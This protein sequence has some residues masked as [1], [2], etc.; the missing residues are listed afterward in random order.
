MYA[1]LKYIIL[2]FLLIG[3]G[4]TIFNYSKLSE[5]EPFSK[6]ISPLVLFTLLII[7]FFLPRSL[8]MKN[9]TLTLTAFGI[10]IIFSII[11]AFSTFEY[12]DS[13]RRNKVYGEYSGLGCAEMEKKFASDLENNELKYFS[14][15]MFYNKN[16]GK[17]LDKLGIEEFYQGCII[18]V[19]FE[20]YRNLLEEHLKKEKSIDLEKLWN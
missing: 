7:F 9:I 12:F 6:F 13:E 5:Y 16:F 19:D 14:G 17:E 10:G 20:C 4:L 3:L 11:S 15:G 18:I 8:K 1:K 2:V